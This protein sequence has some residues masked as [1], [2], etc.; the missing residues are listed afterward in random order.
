MPFIPEES[1]HCNMRIVLLLGSL[2]LGDVWKAI[3]V[4]GSDPSGCKSLSITKSQR[5]HC[6][7]PAVLATRKVKD[8]A[9]EPLR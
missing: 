2:A 6:E 5:R 9:T 3:G 8:R 7:S 1:W 4:H